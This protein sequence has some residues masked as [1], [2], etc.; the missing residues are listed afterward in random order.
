MIKTIKKRILA[1]AVLGLL[2]TGCVSQLEKKPVQYDDEIVLTNGIVRLGVSPSIGRIVS[3]GK[4]GSRDLLWRNSV[5][6]LNA[7][8]Q[9]G[10]GWLNY[11]GDK[12]WPGVQDSWERIFGRQWPPV[13]AVD[14]KKWEV[15]E[16]STLRIVIESQY[17][18][19]LQAK[20][21]REIVLA[22]GK[23]AVVITN[24]LD[25]FSNSPFPVCLWSITQIKA[26]VYCLLD[27]DEKRPA[28]NNSYIDFEGDNPNTSLLLKGKVLKFFARQGQRN[29]IGTFGKWIAA[30]YPD[31]IFLQSTDYSP[32]GC[33][34][35][36]ASL[37]CYWDDLVE[38]MNNK[39]WN[40]KYAELELLG[41]SRHIRPGEKIRNVVRWKIIDNPKKEDAVIARLCN[42]SI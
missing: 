6:D 13:E 5:A 17:I 4:V 34:P 8:R 39:L 38:D 23:A 11:G 24:T 15:I 31:C 9:Q 12:L 10:R 36:N 19:M 27:I 18:N 14:G 7:V 28:S 33:Y 42:E 41:V 1:V 21:R 40:P 3:F 16:R 30:V 20:I 22:D 32:G 37:E 35:D 29:K 25:R 2:L 26:P